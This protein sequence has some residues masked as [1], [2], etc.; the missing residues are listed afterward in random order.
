MA[1]DATTGLVRRWPGA[2]PQLTV[3]HPAR[4]AAARE[5]LPVGIALAGACYDGLGIASC[6][7][8]GEVAAAALPDMAE[9][10]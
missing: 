1:A 9:M 10:R 3:G 8:S 4:L 2:L 5:T 7:R 6:V